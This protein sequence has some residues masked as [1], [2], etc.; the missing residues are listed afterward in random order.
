[1]RQLNTGE[2]I[3][4]RRKEL[5]LSAEALGKLI[6]KDRA[7]I[8]RYEKNE[9]ENIPYTLIVE[10]ASVLHVHPA[11]LM[12]WDDGPTDL[13]SERTYFPTAISA[14]LPLEVDGITEASKIS[15]SDEVL[16]RYAKDKD[17]FFARINGDSMNRLMADGSLI[18]VKPV[19]STEN[20]VN[21][22]IVVYSNGG[23]YSVKHFYKY[24]DTLVF[25]PN[26]TTVHDEHTYNAKEDNVQ[27]HG[28]VVTYI[29]NVD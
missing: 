3:K 4:E 29:V 22:D 27:I 17:I 15:I 8:Y 28:K 10:L 9:I 16:G 24:G 23:D 5:K 2:R 13:V 25:K 12:C 6:G 20:L 14:G 11:Y 19:N 26:S 1:M 21:G 18:A 7:T